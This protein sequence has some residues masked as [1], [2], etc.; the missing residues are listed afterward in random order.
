MIYILIIFFLLSFI[1]FV[2]RNI[3]KGFVAEYF[4]HCMLKILMPRGSYILHDT[5]LSFKS[6]TT[7][8]IDHIVIARTG[9]FVIET[10]NM[11]GKIYGKEND[12]G[13]MQ[14]YSNYNKRPF[15]NPLK[16]NK[17]HVDAVKY[18]TGEHFVFN[19]VYFFS[20]S[21]ENI[22]C[23]NNVFTSVFQLVG[24]VKKQKNIYSLDDIKKI[25]IKLKT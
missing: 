17:I 6:G 25:K 12:D 9:I 11:Q 19:I 18:V 20:P 7:T 23:V 2:P 16:Q 8:Q 4:L 13:W 1:V 5:T 15:L 24:F 10:K 22:Q 14:V 3:L 21:V